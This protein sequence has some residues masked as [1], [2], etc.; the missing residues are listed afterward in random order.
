MTYDEAQEL[1]EEKYNFTVNS[2]WIAHVLSIHGK[3]KHKASNRLGKKVSNPCPDNIRP[4]LEIVL[5][6]LGML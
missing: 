4:K 5:I 6:E 3:T 2:S 1:F